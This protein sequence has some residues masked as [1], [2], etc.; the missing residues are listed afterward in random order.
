M[1]REKIGE[2]TVHLLLKTSKPLKSGK[3]PLYIR[4]QNKSENRYYSA[5]SEMSEKEWA[6]FEKNPESDHPAVLYYKSF[7]QSA[8]KLV[9]NRDF[10]FDNL[11]RL[12]GRGST[13]SLQD[14]SED[15]AQEFHKRRKY[16]SENLYHNLRVSIDRFTEGKPLPVTQMTPERCKQFLTFLSEDMG[17]SPTT[18]NIKARNLTTILNRAVSMH[19]IGSNPMENVKKPQSSRREMEVSEETL[20]KLLTAT[21][22]DLGDEARWLDLWR[23]IYYGNGMNMKDLLLLKWKNIDRVRNEIRF[24]RH[25]TEDSSG[26]TIKVP[27]IPELLESLER[28]YVP[29]NEYLLP[30]LAGV[31]SE[32][33]EEY[34]K[35]RQT[36]KN[37]N[38]HLKVITRMLKIPEK[39][40]T[41]TGRHAFAT[42]LMQ[43]SVSIA[44]ISKAM[45]HKNIKTTQNYLEGFT[46]TQRRETAFKLLPD[47]KKDRRNEK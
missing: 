41:Y 2:V 22:Y 39:I 28:V 9:R 24:T 11:S 14:L 7:V 10:S 29:G 3:Y 45:G 35:I 34:R 44:F 32:S 15:N 12:T 1:I 31:P 47:T 20:S 37:A 40:T 38:K 43:E 33:E 18:V 8:D 17:N 42:K 21:E 36:T 4:I 19:L 16:N 26:A 25:K 13:D 46:E 27:L 6:R 23:C 30:Y 5:H